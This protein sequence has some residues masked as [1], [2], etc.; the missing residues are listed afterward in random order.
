M[1]KLEHLCQAW[2]ALSDREKKEKCTASE[3][4]NYSRT[5]E[6]GYRPSVQLHAWSMDW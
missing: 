5:S 1:K 6:N 3:S 2:S 4:V